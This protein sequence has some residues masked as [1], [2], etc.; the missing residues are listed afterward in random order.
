MLFISF[1]IY[2]FIDRKKTILPNHNRASPVRIS[3][4]PNNYKYFAVIQGH[5]MHCV[6]Y[7]KGTSRSWKN[8][9][10]VEFT[11]VMTHPT[12][13]LVATGDKLG[14]IFLWREIFAKSEP[15]TALYHW[16]HTPVNTIAFTLSGSHF[17]SGGYEN[18]LVK[19][20]ANAAQ[21]REYVPRM[22]GA[23][24]HIVVG[25]KNL[26]V[27]VAA[28]DNGIQILD[29]QLQQKVVIQNF[30]WIPNDKTN[31]CKF[32]IGLKVN[33]RNS[34][35]VLNGRVGH[36]QFYSTHTKNFLYNVSM[37][38][39]HQ[40]MLVKLFMSLIPDFGESSTKIATKIYIF[41]KIPIIG[42]I[43][44][45]DTTIQNRLN[46]E[47][48]KVL[49]NTMVTHS[50][51]N[52]NWLVTA[53]YLDDGDHTIE[54]RLKF[55]SFDQDKQT[56]ALNTQI[57]LPHEGGVKALE[58]STPYSVESLLCASGGSREVKLWA[59]EDSDNIHSKFYL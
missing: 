55:W 7:I 39:Y 50:A 57:E 8:A 54:S 47:S 45:M 52:M 2:I 14:R 6:N 10:K 19:W 29:A 42:F 48:D 1:F 3:V 18:V 51:L 26:K 40:P 46:I 5:Y 28:D 35:L 16:H 49:Y 41:T 37:S 12:E 11:C 38:A 56:Y 17:Y 20:N 30:T 4:A 44:Q 21:E 58:F 53:E 24:M 43:T 36:L 34:S 31:V 33:P 32:P 13:Q 15:M 22:W 27:A 23:A 59:L 9:Q 25:D